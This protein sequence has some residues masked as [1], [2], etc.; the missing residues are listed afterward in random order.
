MRSLTRAEAIVIQSLLASEEVT[1]REHIRRSGLP[2]RTFEVAR[3]RVLAAGW[4]HQRYIPNPLLLGRDVVTVVLAH[5]Y[6][7]HLQDVV[8]QWRET[9]GNVVLWRGG[10]SVLGV[11][12][13]PH[14]SASLKQD[15][16]RGSPEAF[17]WIRVLEVDLRSSAVPVYFDFGGAWSRVIDARGTAAYPHPLPESNS[18]TQSHG[19]ASP[20][21]LNLM[22][23]I[24]RSA[25]ES[26][27]VAAEVGNIR[28]VLGRDR[29]DRAIKSGLVSRRAF[30]GFDSVPG[31]RAWELRQVVFLSGHLRSGALGMDLLR[32]LNSKVGLNP[33]LFVNDG[34]NILCALLSP[35]PHPDENANRVPNPSVVGTFQAFI[36]EI[37]VTREPVGELAILVDH[38][39]D[40]LFSSTLKGGTWDQLLV[41][42]TPDTRYS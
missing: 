34:G 12:F 41:S 20:F 39:Y 36:S 21:D 14:S 15:L 30:L 40:R 2:P 8:S 17:S 23:S 35:N 5:P 13:R 6:A 11:F 28:T 9:D 38:R 22:E 19:Q 37:H 27:K 3:K 16:S 24:T 32:A 1:D 26:S 42:G 33:L 7:E 10:T 25:V 4:V 31:Y 18:S 29:I